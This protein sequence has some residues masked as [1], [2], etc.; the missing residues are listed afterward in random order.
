MKIGDG[1]SG[2][3]W[4]KNCGPDTG[5]GGGGG[6]TDGDGGGCGVGLTI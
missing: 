2:G 5:G 1:C 4:L 3:Y 6:F